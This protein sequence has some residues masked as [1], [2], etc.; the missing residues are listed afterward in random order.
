MTVGP[1]VVLLFSQI[2]AV[3]QVLEIRP[4]E[5]QAG[6]S[7]TLS[8]DTS[9]VPAF[10]MGFGTIEGKGSATVAPNFSTDYT[11]ITETAVGV[12]FTPVRLSVAGAK[13]DDGY[14]ALSDFGVALWGT[15]SGISYV[16]FQKAVWA[17][18]QAKGY[19][20]KGDYAPERPFV[21][22]YTDFALPPGLVSSEEKIRARRLAYAVEI[23]QPEKSGAIP[24]GVRLRLEFQY[25]GENKWR[26]DMETSLGKSEAMKTLQSLQIVK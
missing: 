3:A 1:V 24:F 25:P 8:W 19:L 5:I 2:T 26:P 21:V 15:R 12:R 9:G 22:V 16:D 10:V 18:L 23:Y 17:A 20:V 7:A 14:P 13:G 11:M 4:N 6:Q